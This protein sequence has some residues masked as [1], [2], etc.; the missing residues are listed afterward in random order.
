MSAGLKL[1][2]RIVKNQSTNTPPLSDFVDT[3][4]PTVAREHFWPL[5]GHW[6]L[7]A[8]LLL[9]RNV[10]S[11]LSS[12]VGPTRTTWLQLC[13]ERFFQPGGSFDAKKPG[14]SDILFKKVLVEGF[15]GDPRE[16]YC[17]TPLHRNDGVYAHVVTR[18]FDTSYYRVLRFI[19]EHKLVLLARA[20]LGPAAVAPLMQSAAKRLTER[21][22][23]GYTSLEDAQ[24]TV[25]LHPSKIDR[26][27]GLV[28]CEYQRR[29]SSAFT[30]LIQNDTSAREAR[31]YDCFDELSLYFY[32]DTWGSEAS[33]LP[34]VRGSYNFMSCSAVRDVS[35]NY[36]RYSLHC[37]ATHVSNAESLSQKVH[38]NRM[39][40]M[41]HHDQPFP[42][43][44]PRRDPDDV[45]D[46]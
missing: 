25:D 13:R 32:Y 21:F 29:V 16:F 1:T 15:R 12:S 46:L 4:G 17:D 34:L 5:F 24:E 19:P 40:L 6:E 20:A 28:V 18:E 22:L 26:C 44:S 30:A 41:F 33:D 10:S 43:A 23:S 39:E 35:G 45:F 9:S 7:A 31:N 27:S 36:H 11:Q 14:C 37:E 2:K 3:L 8:L 38:S 42:W